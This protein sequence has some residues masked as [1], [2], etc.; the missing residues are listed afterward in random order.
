MGFSLFKKKAA[1]VSAAEPVTIN[2]I[3]THADAP[4]PHQDERAWKSEAVRNAKHRAHVFIEVG[5]ARRVAECFQEFPALEALCHLHR[6]ADTYRHNSQYGRADVV[7]LAADYIRP[8]EHEEAVPGVEHWHQYRNRVP[9]VRRCVPCEIL[10]A[11][12]GMEFRLTIVER[13]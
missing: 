2:V 10:E 3:F 13:T 7:L 12:V 8:K 5:D 4:K 6:L 11:P 9:R 1:E